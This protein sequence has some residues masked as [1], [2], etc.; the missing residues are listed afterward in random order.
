MK[1]PFLALFAIQRRC[2]SWSRQCPQLPRYF[3]S[4]CC[5]FSGPG[6]FKGGPKEPALSALVHYFLY[7]LWYSDIWSIARF[8]RWKV[9]SVYH[10]WFTFVD[11]GMVADVYIN[12]YARKQDREDLNRSAVSPNELVPTSAFNFVCTGGIGCRHVWPY[13]CNQC[14]AQ[15]ELQEDSIW[16][17]WIRYCHAV[18]Q[19]NE[20]L[21]QAGSDSTGNGPEA[22]GSDNYTSDQ[23]TK[24]IAGSS[25]VLLYY[26]G[27]L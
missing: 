16:R 27:L 23:V 26:L 13:V 22:D 15:S 18:V 17:C 2:F 10:H 12:R 20:R 5:A 7:I 24:I 6:N 8:A 3:N 19:A 4:I 21:L 1:C 25:I 11:P 14:H 9:E